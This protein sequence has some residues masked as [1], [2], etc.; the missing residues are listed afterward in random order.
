M[1]YIG[2]CFGCVAVLLSVLFL[3]S[4]IFCAVTDPNAEIRTAVGTWKPSSPSIELSIALAQWSVVEKA[5][6]GK[7]AGPNTWA[8]LT[9]V[10][11]ALEVFASSKNPVS[12]AIYKRVVG[13]MMTAYNG[14]GISAT[15]L[16][17]ADGYPYIKISAGDAN[18]HYLNQ[19]VSRAQRFANFGDVLID[20][21][22]L[23]NVEKQALPIPGQ[24]TTLY[25]GFDDVFQPETLVSGVHPQAK[26][27]I[28]FP[29]SPQ[30]AHEILHGLLEAN[31]QKRVPSPFYGD[32]LPAGGQLAVPGYPKGIG[33]GEVPAT[34][35]EIVRMA[36]STNFAQLEGMKQ[37]LDTVE[38]VVALF[39]NFSTS[40]GKSLNPRAAE[41]GPGIITIPF[42]TDRIITGTATFTVTDGVVRGSLNVGGGVIY[43]APL[44]VS[45]GISDPLNLNNLVR[46]F[47]DQ[48]EAVAQ[49]RDQARTLVG[50]Q[51]E[52]MEI[53][54]SEMLTERLALM[55]EF[56][57]NGIRPVIPAHAKNSAL[58]SRSLGLPDGGAPTDPTLKALVNAL[59]EDSPSTK[60]VEWTNQNGRPYKGIPGGLQLDPNLAF[61]PPSSYGETVIPADSADRVLRPVFD[62][63][64]GSP[65]VNP[66]LKAPVVALGWKVESG[67]VVSPEGKKYVNTAFGSDVIDVRVQMRTPNLAKPSDYQAL[68]DGV[69]KMLAM[70]NSMS[71]DITRIVIT[72]E[73]TRDYF[74]NHGTRN[75]VINLNLLEVKA[76]Q[77]AQR[78]A[79][80]WIERQLFFQAAAAPSPEYLQKKGIALTDGSFDA[81]ASERR[82]L[83][84]KARDGDP[85]AVA[86]L[87]R[88]ELDRLGRKN[89]LRKQLPQSGLFSSLPTELAAA[90]PGGDPVKQFSELAKKNT[91]AA[92][93]AGTSNGA[94][95]YTPADIQKAPPIAG[96]AQQTWSLRGAPLGEGTIQF[97]VKPDG[98]GAGKPVVDVFLY[99][100]IQKQPGSG[101]F[102]LQ[103][104]K[105]ANPGVPIRGGSLQETN[106]REFL[107]V[108]AADP[109]N[110]N[111]KSIPFL[112]AENGLVDVN[113]SWNPDGTFSNVELIAYPGSSPK[114][115][116]WNPVNR[117]AVLGDPRFRTFVA[118]LNPPNGPAVDLELARL[119]SGSATSIAQQVKAIVQGGGAAATSAVTNNPLPAQPGKKILDIG[120]DKGGTAVALAAGV[121]GAGHLF[122]AT[123]AVGAP[124]PVAPIVLRISVSDENV[125]TKNGLTWVNA[126]AVN[127]AMNNGLARMALYPSASNPQPAA[128]ALLEMAQGFNV[129]PKPGE[130]GSAV[131]N[132]LTDGLK[133]IDPTNPKE[134][135][136]PDKLARD[137]LLPGLQQTGFKMVPNYSNSPNA[138]PSTVLALSDGKTMGVPA[139]GPEILH[140]GYQKPETV[141]AMMPAGSTAILGVPTETSSVGQQ[142]VG[143]ASLTGL[144]GS[145]KTELT[146][147]VLGSGGQQAAR[148]FVSALYNLEIGNVF[149]VGEGFTNLGQSLL[150]AKLTVG[151]MTFVGL[152]IT[153]PTGAGS[154]TTGTPTLLLGYKGNDSGYK[155]LSI[156]TAKAGLATASFAINTLGVPALVGAYDAAL[157]SLYTN[158][159]GGE[160]TTATLKGAGAGVR[161]GLNS[162]NPLTINGALN[163]ISMGTMFALDTAGSAASGVFGVVLGGIAVVDFAGSLYQKNAMLAD[164]A[165]DNLLGSAQMAFISGDTKRYGAYRKNVMRFGYDPL[166]LDDPYVKAFIESELT[167][168]E[169]FGQRF[170]EDGLTPTQVADAL[171]MTWYTS[172][173]Q[174][175]VMSKKGANERTWLEFKLKQMGPLSQEDMA[176]L[177]MMREEDQASYDSFQTFLYTQS[178]MNKDTVRGDRLVELSREANHARHDLGMVMEASPADFIPK[179]PTFPA[180][181]VEPNDPMLSALQ[182]LNSVPGVEY[183]INSVETLW[184]SSDLNRTIAVLRN[185]VDPYEWGV[186]YDKPT[187]PADRAPWE[188]KIGEDPLF[189]PGSVNLWNSMNVSVDPYALPFTYG[190]LNY[191]STRTGDFIFWGASTPQIPS[192]YGDFG[193][194][195]TPPDSGYLNF[196]TLVNSGNFFSQDA[197]CMFPPCGP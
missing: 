61:N 23:A 62:G 134:F 136:I 122:L 40:L 105:A 71:G 95:A 87:N 83:I 20:P 169:Q 86:E 90:A 103:S 73:P 47:R 125:V 159:S 195:Y 167:W 109:V 52:A 155:G 173:I 144:L 158:P 126:T 161:Q 15:S 66:A 54:D 33:I 29:V 157:D 46:Y 168:G 44:L 34:H 36:G 96:S 114:G 110:P 162:L 97:T 184:M 187:I 64:L 185:A 111:L 98:L 9:R 153:P 12:D 164:A 26:S 81:F 14:Q 49:V 178:L 191:T 174:A 93:S 148:S 82:A 65:K 121:L 112:S 27:V 2:R 190:G 127:G 180:L 74:L 16:M 175:E 192:A 80:L 149:S 108:I 77:G 100:G 197:G 147:R 3:E 85:D 163:D 107:D 53:R 120:I 115:P 102:L 182:Y 69:T 41:I 35:E 145:G 60:P 78:V 165:R 63:I 140:L 133:S 10:A 22:I 142:V 79:E 186:Q 137:K 143:F 154:S 50:M 183:R 150:G 39:D 21:K 166:G 193:M 19:F 196:D 194:S 131:I 151:G 13:E 181:K 89:D 57:R 42:S 179:P 104:V 76:G 8:P 84:Q 188:K 32:F 189:A 128:Q 55:R 146:S 106:L 130:P 17:S 67:T 25:L 118:S 48:Y 129:V 5:W 177:N 4:S 156:N 172:E 43:S 99:Y 37:R 123:P 113:I 116:V 141:D 176:L 92:L 170:V 11:D 132:V 45:K 94:S 38:Q 139:A 31:L 101:S 72:D 68:A 7:P 28:P 124:P 119:Q 135:L 56:Q 75:D 117:Q 18:S 138:V 88:E 171:A 160:L 70:R 91:A 24:K 6:V 59:V 1:T 58:A 51:S 152:H 30:N